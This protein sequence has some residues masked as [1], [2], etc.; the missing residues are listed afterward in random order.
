MAKVKKVESKL[1]PGKPTNPKQE[2]KA[3]AQVKEGKPTNPNEVVAL[4]N[5]VE[6]TF[7]RQIWDHLP[8]GKEGFKEV[9]SAPPPV[10]TI[11]VKKVDLTYEDAVKEYTELFG[12]APGQDLDLAAL[13]VAIENKKGEQGNG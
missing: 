13:H 8:A 5:G 7:S 9:V 2:V 11:A 1:Q 6:R 12:E 10:K 4:K 3:P